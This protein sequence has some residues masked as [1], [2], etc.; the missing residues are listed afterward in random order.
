MSRDTMRLSPPLLAYLRSIAVPPDR[1]LERLR[2][3]TGKLEWGRMQVSPEQGQLMALLVQ[4]MGAQRAIEV[5]VFTGYSGL[6]TARALGP[7]GYLVACDIDPDTTAMA[8]RY[9][10]EAGVLDRIDLR[11]APALDT[12]DALIADGQSGTYD[13][14]FLDADKENYP[15]YLDRCLTLLRPGGL[16]AADNT[17]WSGAVIDPADQRPSTK[18]IRA[19]NQAASTDPRLLTAMV[20]IADGLTLCVKS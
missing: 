17:L 7:G 15:S 10:R 1:V 14:A 13:F 12:L 9:W 6:V 19:F 5:G 4:L 8:Q 2:E 3:E 16:V 20:P 18:G 11:L